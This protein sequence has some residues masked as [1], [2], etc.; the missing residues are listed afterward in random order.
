M[1]KAKEEATKEQNAIIERA[2]LDMKMKAAGAVGV[3]E[4][5]D[6][7][8]YFKEPSRYAI[9]ACMATV[10]RDV[11]AACEIIFNDCVIQDADWK[12]FTENKGAFI[13]LVGPL[14]RLIP[15]KKSTFRP[16]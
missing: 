1:A 3:A 4:H 6:K 9:G 2:E 10:D 15:L 7:V 5:E 16:L 13:G 14:Q 11:V 8:V 12:Y